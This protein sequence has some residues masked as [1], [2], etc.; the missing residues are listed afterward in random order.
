MKLEE[1]NIDGTDKLIVL[2]SSVG[3]NIIDID[4]SIRYPENSTHPNHQVIFI[5]D[6]FKNDVKNKIILT[7]SPYI[8]QAIRY[9]AALNGIENCV[10]YYDVTHVITDVTTTLNDVFAS[11]AEPINRIMNVDQA[12]HSRNSEH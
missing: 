12:R 2:T 6:M 7:H 11:F 3:I 1:L 8:L 4:N 10:K 5:Q 9:Y